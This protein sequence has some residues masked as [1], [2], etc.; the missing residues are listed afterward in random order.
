LCR[1]RRPK[2][3]FYAKRKNKSIEESAREVRYRFLT[4]ITRRKKAG[5]I[6]TAHTRDDQAET[7]LMRIIRGTGIK[8]MGAMTSDRMEEGEIKVIRPLLSYSKREILSALNQAKIPYRED[9]SN[10]Q[11]DFLRN[12]IRRQ[13]I[14]KIEREYNP[15]VTH[16]LIGLSDEARGLYDFLR[17]EA[18]IALKKY[19]RRHNGSV[20]LPIGKLSNIHPA[21]LNEILFQAIE[22][23]QGNRRKLTRK[24]L[25]AISSLLDGPDRTIQSLPKGLKAQRLKNQLKVTRI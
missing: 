13:L 14:P 15:H 4:K 17:R 16:N 3:R 22:E 2:G 8:G 21:L 9:P 5:I 20:S 11:M 19:R 23:V 1:P 12:R 6:L 18:G 10:R 25:N 7:V 24:H